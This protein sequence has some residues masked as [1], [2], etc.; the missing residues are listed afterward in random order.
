VAT[1][2]IGILTLYVALFAQ[3]A[4]GSALLIAPSVLE[5]A[6]GHEVATR[7]YVALARFATSL[8]TIG[9]ALGAVLE[10]DEAM[11]EAAYLASARGEAAEAGDSSWIP[12]ACSGC[13]SSSSR[14]SRCSSAR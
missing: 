11:R 1:V 6:L 14:C 10:S 9:G 2:T 7:D 12:S 5:E 13:S 3:I 4:A 8:A